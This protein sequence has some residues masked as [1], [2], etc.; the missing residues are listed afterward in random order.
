M[1]DMKK[2]AVTI[3][4]VSALG[5][6]IALGEGCPS[7]PPV[8]PPPDASDAL[9]PPGPTEDGAPPTPPGPAPNAACLQACATLVKVGCAF[10]D[11]GPACG[12]FFTRDLA[13]GKIANAA[14]GKPLTCADIAAATTKAQIVALGFACP[15]PP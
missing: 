11:S 2:I 3:I 10:G 1:S 7:V 9:A 15:S 12:A 4:A 8:A 5:A 6:G 14:T 13:I